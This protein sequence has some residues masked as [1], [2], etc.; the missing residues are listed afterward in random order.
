MGFE[1]AGEGV[2]VVRSSTRTWAIQPVGSP[3]FSSAGVSSAAKQRTA[4]AGADSCGQAAVS[5]VS[6]RTGDL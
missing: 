2:Q 3:A 5:V 4:S 1:P 6:I